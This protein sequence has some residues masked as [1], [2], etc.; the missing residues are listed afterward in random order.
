MLFLVATSVSFA[1]EIYFTSGYSQTG[2]VIRETDDSVRFRTG[3]GMSTISK[4]K[5]SFIDKAAPEE[6][7]QLLRKWEE[8]RRK[9]KGAAEARR[10]AQREFEQEQIA[11]G[12]VRFAGKWMTPGQKQELIALRKEA[13]EHYRKFEARQ[14]AKG[15]V[16]F[17]HIW[18]TPDLARELTQMEP[19]IIRLNE[20]I[21]EAEYLMDSYRTAMLTVSSVEEAQ[22][23][24]ERIQ[25]IIKTRDENIIKLNS[26]LDRADAIEAMSVTYTM[27]EKYREAF[28]D[29]QSDEPEFE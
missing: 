12:L 3:V 26:L 5:I 17:Q 20:S 1:D 23:F 25:E 16:Q 15:L 19:K 6:N 7:R 24:S 14:R 27:P 28:P 13:R 2:V 22:E 10:E 9:K 21:M 18:V 4:D 8:E 11:K 29:E